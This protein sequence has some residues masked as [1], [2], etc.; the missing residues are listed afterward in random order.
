MR[1]LTTISVVLTFSAICLGQD[2]KTQI[3]KVPIEYT[4]PTSGPD[5]FKTYCAACH[6]PDG[7]GTGP[8]ASALKK[9]PADLTLL[10]SKNGGK[11]P[12]LMVQNTIRGESGTVGAH[13]SR[14]MPMWGD[15]F[16]SVSTGD[17]VV[18]LQ[19]NAECAHE[20]GLGRHDDRDADERSHSQRHRPIVA[21]TA[22]HEDAAADRASPPYP[23]QIVEADG[24]DQAGQ[25]IVGAHPFLARRLHIAR[26]ERRALVAKIGR[27]L[28]E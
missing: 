24:I 3:K 16:H 12:A 21:D 11:F 28:T 20:T 9:A 10:S 22:L 19:G 15:I 2:Q 18:D 25:D 5:M 14:D 13:G 17:A 7:K 23:V 27:R 26:Y 6:G 1:T 8:A 4:K